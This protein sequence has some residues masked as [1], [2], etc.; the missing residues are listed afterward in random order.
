M[1]Q[2]DKMTFRHILVII[3]GILILFGPCALTYNTWSIFV[4]PVSTDLGTNSAQFTAY[5]T[6]IYLVSA[7]A[8][9]FV[10][11]LMERFDLRIVLSASVI[12][13][14]IGIGLCAV[15]TEVWQFYI[16][17]VIEGLGIISC[18]FLAV[19]TLINRWFA[20]R[21]GFLIGL[22]MAMSGVG[23]AFWSFIG[24]VVISSSGY[25]A[26]YALYAVA[27]LVLALPATLFFVRS[28][29]EDVGLVPLGSVAFEQDELARSEVSS[30]SP[31]DLEV[32]QAPREVSEAREGV[33][34]KSIDAKTFF[35]TPTFFALMIAVGLFNALT[36][37]GNLVPSY[38]YFLGD[39]AI[40]GVTSDS[41]IMIS[42]TIASLFM[43]VAAI[44]KVVLGM[45]CDK[46]PLL[47]LL[48]SGAASI[49]GIIA[50]WTCGL[51]VG[52]LYIGAVGVGIM[53]AM[54]DSLGPNF[55]RALVG[56]R[57]YTIIY[58]RIS[59]FV[60]L[61]GA[62]AVVGFS[63]VSEQGWD[64]LWIATLATIA[65]SLVLAL[66]ALRSSKKLLG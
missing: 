56:P 33:R 38:V 25:Q 49:I 58:S 4:V 12:L 40:A 43:I 7:I 37:A 50:V 23:G 35:K 24:G 29:P 10:G 34:Q 54:I 26:A 53:Y 57:D 48:V 5:I 6:V 27:T 61:A 47:S 18:M 22:C 15:W 19:P 1:G 17:G 62:A 44:S 39:H 64:L 14:G 55:T 9:P 3:A 52:L 65:L 32:G 45:L 2:N 30:R 16:S 60:N 11:D 59:V 36:A 46:S 63:L 21:T 31:Q 42:A 13:V 41:A 28:R 20:K 66:Y 51:W 8:A